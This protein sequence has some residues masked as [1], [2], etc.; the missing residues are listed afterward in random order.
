MDAIDEKFM[1]NSIRAEGII[2]KLKAQR[3]HEFGNPRKPH[4]TV[5]NKSA[6]SGTL[7][8][9][10]DLEPSS[11]GRDNS[12]SMPP[13][14]VF[15]VGHRVVGAIPFIDAAKARPPL[16]Q[17][18]HTPSVHSFENAPRFSK[19]APQQMTNPQRPSSRPSPRSSMSNRAP[20]S[21][22]LA[23]PNPDFRRRSTSHNTA[24]PSAVPDVRRSS[25]YQTK[26][27]AKSSI[28]AKPRE[29]KGNKFDEVEALLGMRK[30]LPIEKY[31]DGSGEE[32]LRTPNK[33]APLNPVRK[34]QGK[35][36]PEVQPSEGVSKLEKRSRELRVR[37][38]RSLNALLIQGCVRALAPECHAVKPLQDDASSAQ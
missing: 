25:S 34:P 3:Q 19:V 13:I 11:D 20:S 35:A 26:L 10:K 7:V 23:K 27:D 4:S 33:V 17:A 14:G 16:H 31:Y 8:L 38:C 24:R 22:N 21:K 28:D 18:A 2:A 30:G 29:T 37:T 32:R 9:R 36:A 5:R 12:P 6:L 15:N 1:R